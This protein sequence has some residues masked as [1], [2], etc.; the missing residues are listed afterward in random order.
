MLAPSDSQCTSVDIVLLQFQVTAS[1]SGARLVHRVHHRA[2][3]QQAS[4][5]RSRGLSSSAAV[6]QSEQAA[7]E[8]TSTSDSSNI[9]WDAFDAHQ[10]AVSRL[11][12]AE[13]VRLLLDSSRYKSFQIKTLQAG[14]VNL[15]VDI[16]PDAHS[17]IL[18]I[19]LSHAGQ[20][21]SL[22]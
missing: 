19:V 20:A 22:P 16:L 2:I 11:S 10:K 21:F 18:S 13:E 9:D 1:W 7:S 14:T 17:Q 5:R 8:Q 4:C 15:C 12:H 3:T 6:Q